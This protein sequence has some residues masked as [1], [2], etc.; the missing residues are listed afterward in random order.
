MLRKRWHYSG[1]LCT[2]LSCAKTGRFLIC[3]L[4]TVRCLLVRPARY[5]AVYRIGSY[6]HTYSFH[7]CCL[8]L[9]L[10]GDPSQHQAEPCFFTPLPSCA[11]QLPFLLVPCC[12]LGSSAY[13]QCARCSL[14][15]LVCPLF[16]E[17][18]LII[19]VLLPQTYFLPTFE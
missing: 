2:L 4:L 15:P 1:V 13:L 9:A 7:V 6:I 19:S 10:S 12:F 3:L 18:P 16:Y 8:F 11:F 14:A 5:S 17:V